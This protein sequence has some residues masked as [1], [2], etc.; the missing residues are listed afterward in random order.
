MS[1][2][3]LKL[4][5]VLILAADTV[6]AQ[7]SAVL[8]ISPVIPRPAHA[9]LLPGEYMLQGDMEICSPAEFMPEARK[10]AEMIPLRV[11]L[12]VR[13][14]QGEAEAGQCGISI[15][16]REDFESEEY[17]LTIDS[18]GILIKASE[19]V[20]V[21]WAIQTLRQLFPST[22]ESG[23]RFT[24]L[25]L[26][27]LSISDKP[28]FSWRGAMLDCSRHFR[29]TRY[30]KRFLDL[31]ALHKLNRF[32][33]H[34]TDDQ[35][36]RLEIRSR[37]LLTSIGSWRMENGVP[38][39][40]YYTQNDVRDIV[41]YAAKRHIVVVPEIDMPGHVSSVLAA[42]PELGC[43]N[44][45]I[46]VPTTWGIFDDVLC[47]SRESTYDFIRDVFREV[48]ALFP[49]PWIHIGGDEAPTVRWMECP[50]CSK[51]LHDVGNDPK[52]LQPLF[53]TRVTSMLDSLGK[54]AIGWNEILFDSLSQQTIIQAWH[55]V[56]S[57]T[58]AMQMGHR[59][60]VS[61]HTDTYL[62]HG[63][64]TLPLKRVYSFEP[65]A[66]IPT[67]IDTSLYLGIEANLW[68]ESSPTEEIADYRLFP[69]LPAVAEVAWSPPSLRDWEDFKGRL[70]YFGG[71]LERLGVNFFEDPQIVWDSGHALTV[72]AVPVNDPG[73]VH[74][75]FSE[76][77]DERAMLNFRNYTLSLTDGS[78]IPLRITSVQRITPQI[79]ECFLS[80]DKNVS[81]L[82]LSISNVHAAEHSWKRVLDT[83]SSSGVAQV[84][85]PPAVTSQ[86][87][88]DLWPNPVYATGSTA[89]L[90]VLVLTRQAED[91]R[92]S[93]HNALG[94]LVYTVQ[95]RAVIFQ[96]PASQLAAGTYI[97]TV[98]A[99]TFIDHR[100]IVVLR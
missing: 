60:I 39:G 79:V 34:L 37:P 94:E 3:L 25:R 30:I 50:D 13:E 92:L 57:A 1:K 56:S 35:G 42:Y 8:S 20:G 18:T 43:R 78:P 64:A 45:R 31:M 11:D 65:I 27:C 48:A 52:R 87:S 84:V 97:L 89:H 90:S 100:S 32:H 5:L 36:W 62:N 22:M 46:E 74:V 12:K 61:P 95:G 6:S 75:L 83:V 73:I 86:Y 53:S 93:L 82:L 68:A 14:L 81:E 10:L 88:I 26:P 51:R 23:A 58:T 16:R 69:R 59:C 55:G 44:E 40:G 2:T 29:S 4:T 17:R 80:Y 71:R 85:I 67:A 38:Y 49:A 66:P 54:E 76:E 63:Y 91:M 15:I 41:A 21:Y 96:I 24:A 47:I 19:A 9:E 33:W 28:R 99:D 7:N 70:G 77:V 98:Q 72:S